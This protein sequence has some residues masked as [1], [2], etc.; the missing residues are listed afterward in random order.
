MRTGPLFHIEK[1]VFFLLLVFLPTQFGKHFWPSFSSVLGIRVD[2]LSPTLFATDILVG[3]LLMVVLSQKKKA[4][5]FFNILRSTLFILFLCSLGVSILGS[6]QPLAGIYGFVRFIEFFFVG[7]FVYQFTRERKQ[8]FLKTLAMAFSITV[9][10]ESLLAIAQFY[11]HGS[12]GGVFYFLGERFYT[13]QTVGIAEAVVNG[14]LVLRPYGTFSHPNVLAG[15]LL[16]G[17]TILTYAWMTLKRRNLFLFGIATGILGIGVTLSRTVVILFLLLFS[18]WV[19]R[20]IKTHSIKQIGIA[21]TAVCLVGFFVSP[22]FDRF[23][24][25]FFKEPSFYERKI[26]IDHAFSLIASSPLFGVGVYNTFYYPVALSA[27][28]IGIFYQ[29]VHN[30]YLLL[31]A[32]IGL[33]G[34][35]IVGVFIYQTTKGLWK[36]RRKGIARLTLTLLCVVGILGMFDHY[37]LSLEQGQL[38]LALV[39]GMATGVSSSNIKSTEMVQ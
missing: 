18:L 25:S 21:V 6:L 13:G 7:W 20:L 8:I 2:Y 27:R 31:V 34:S 16:L 28:T 38:L 23:F 39:L 32:Q 4:F 26:L 22:S 9:I 12:L 19:I 33:V 10:F 15:F 1:F 35:S 30:I 5:R 29:P 14:A 3:I 24:S 36:K 37:F 17:V 11:Q